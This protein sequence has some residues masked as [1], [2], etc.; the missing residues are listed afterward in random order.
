VDQNVPNTE[1]AKQTQ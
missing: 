1:S